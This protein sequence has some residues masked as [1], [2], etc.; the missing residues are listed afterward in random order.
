MGLWTAFRVISDPLYVRGDG[1]RV[2]PREI[3]RASL[4]CFFSPEAPDEVANSSFFEHGEQA[5]ELCLEI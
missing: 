2:F 5:K 4:H 1:F 3:G